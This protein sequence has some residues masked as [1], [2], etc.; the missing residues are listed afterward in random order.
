MT[1]TK[2]IFTVVLAIALFAGPASAQTSPTGS[3]DE[4]VAALLELAESQ[5]RLIKQQQAL[6]DEQ[7]TL[8]DDQEDLLNTYR[9]LFDVDTQLVPD[10]CPSTL[11]EAEIA[12]G[13]LI[14][15]G[16]LAEREQT[17]RIVRR[18]SALVVVLEEGFIST[19]NEHYQRVGRG[20]DQFLARTAAVIP[21][22]SSERLIALFTE[23]VDAIQ[24]LI[25][26][27]DRE[28]SA[29]EI[30]AAISAALDQLDEL[31]AAIGR[32]CI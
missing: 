24:E 1:S 31:D 23:M 2:A 11:T 26:V 8:I 4:R 18:F 5:E 19:D 14:C 27:R 7:Q 16:W 13:E 32:I 12:D 20:A 6:I 15:A 28:A 10:G 25:D 3:A 9:C 17:G 30:A 22:L 29:G 21:I